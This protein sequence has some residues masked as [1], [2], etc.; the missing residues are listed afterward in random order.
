[1]LKLTS[2]VSFLFLSFCLFVTE[3]DAQVNAYSNCFKQL[4]R[5]A[6]IVNKTRRVFSGHLGSKLLFI[7]PVD[8]EPLSWYILSEKKLLRVDF[9][10]A[11]ESQSL[12]AR[13]DRT[14]MKRRWPI[15]KIKVL[16]EGPLQHLY[17][18]LEEKTDLSTGYQEISL[19]PEVSIRREKKIY[20]Q[21][22]NAVREIAGPSFPNLKQVIQNSLEMLPT[23][24]SVKK[25]NWP[26]RKAG[27]EVSDFIKT[28][29]PSC[30]SIVAKSI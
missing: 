19:K 24:D 26:E 18:T 21:K 5:H 12:S 14:Q 23:L 16:E 29:L 15:W 25:L 11:K 2:S 27:Q 4:D 9:A 20:P 30:Y 17:L 1:M 7:H 13:I 28:K 8:S 22:Q 6:L 10:G 3:L